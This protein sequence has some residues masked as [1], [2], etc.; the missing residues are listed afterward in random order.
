MKD[1]RNL[2][3]D[4]DDIVILRSDDRALYVNGVIHDEQ[5]LFVIANCGKEWVVPF[6]DVIAQYK[7]KKIQ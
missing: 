3:F 1:K 4:I 2:E 5:K 7:Q 6:S